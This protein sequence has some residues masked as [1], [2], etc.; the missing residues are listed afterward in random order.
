MCVCVWAVLLFPR[1]DHFL[2]REKRNGSIGCWTF[3]RKPNNRTIENQKQIEFHSKT[4]FF[5][6]ISA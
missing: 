2:E 1:V 3:A 4:R 5:S 6:L